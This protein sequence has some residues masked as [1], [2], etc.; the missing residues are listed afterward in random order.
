[1]KLQTQLLQAPILSSMKDILGE[2][3]APTR[4][5]GC[6]RQGAVFCPH[7]MASL[8][9]LYLQHQACPKCAGPYGALTCTECWE[10][11]YS[12][13]H[14]LALSLLD[15]PLARAIVIYKDGNERRLARCFGALLAECVQ[16]T[17][18]EWLDPDCQ[19]SWIPATA[20]AVRR[21]GFD[22]GELLAYALSKQL[23]IAAL[24]L[25]SRP[26]ARDQRG[27]S[28]KQRMKGF[29]EFTVQPQK[30]KQDLHKV[31][32]IDDVFTTGATLEAASLALLENGAAEVRVAVLG[33]AW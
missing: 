14:A 19:I 9:Y 25:L 22:H 15:G 17:W 12:F 28:R 26:R 27:L 8:P 13:S 16:T 6:E 7:C 3:V 4:C 10:V 32:L 11:S 23:N 31:L 5:A 2:I 20:A 1:M 18:S 30:N 29:K 24:P 33:R 21:R